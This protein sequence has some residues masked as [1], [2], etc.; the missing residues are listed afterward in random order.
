[1][2]YQRFSLSIFSMLALCSFNAHSSV[3]D[4][5]VVSMDDEPRSAPRLLVS[6][7]AELSRSFNTHP[8]VSGDLEEDTSTTTTTIVPM[9]LEPVEAESISI[10]QIKA[11]MNLKI[12]Q[13]CFKALLNKQN[14]FY[15]DKKNPELIEVA[16]TPKEK[17]DF[18]KLRKFERTIKE[19]DDINVKEARKKKNVT[20]NKQ[21]R[22]AI[23]P[24]KRDA[25]N[26]ANRAKYAKVPQAEKEAI[27]AKARARY[28]EKKRAREALGVEQEG[29]SSESEGP[30]TKRQKGLGQ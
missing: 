7:A 14:K 28:A 19:Y 30:S 15:R 20:R 6:G 3:S 1:M 11:Y 23:T 27:N 5:G 13:E 12:N 4:D 26:A 2:M 25:K 21:L 22:D 9:G 10:A 29:S 18:A 24:A 8:L 17:V 16:L